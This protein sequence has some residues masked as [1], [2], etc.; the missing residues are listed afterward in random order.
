MGTKFCLLLYI[1]K[2]MCQVVLD[3]LSDILELESGQLC[4]MV[5][6]T[7]MLAWG[8]T[9]AG[10]DLNLNSSERMA[11]HVHMTPSSSL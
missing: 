3:E 2:L 10:F 9:A 7:D 4:E 5:Q 8:R 11:L 1:C 6:L